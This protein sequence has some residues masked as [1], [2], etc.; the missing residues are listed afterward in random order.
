MAAQPPAYQQKAEHVA[1]SD[2]LAAAPTMISS[3][4]P[5]LTREGSVLVD[6]EVGMTTVCRPL[7]TCS[8]QNI[9]Q[10]E[11]IVL[12]SWIEAARLLTAITEFVVPRSMPTEPVFPVLAFLATRAQGRGRT[13]LWCMPG[14]LTHCR[15]GD[16]CFIRLQ[17]SDS[18]YS[19]C[20]HHFRAHHRGIHT[21]ERSMNLL[22]V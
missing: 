16:A 5:M 11:I 8:P 2:L 3:S 9:A 4:S 19:L 20:D 7:H 18:R 10:N 12:Q 6:C 15:A 13:H 21:Q 22:T 1:W 14:T 17:P